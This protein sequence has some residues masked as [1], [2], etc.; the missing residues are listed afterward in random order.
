L[1]LVLDIWFFCAERNKCFFCPPCCRVR[2]PTDAK[3]SFP[4]PLRALTIKPPQ[5][6]SLP[7]C[8]ACPQH[9][10][11]LSLAISGLLV[12]LPKAP[13]L[14]VAAQPASP[15]V[16]CPILPCPSPARASF[17]GLKHAVKL[18]H[19]HHGWPHAGLRGRCATPLQQRRSRGGRARLPR[20]PRHACSSLS[21]SSRQRW[22]RASCA[23]SATKCPRWWWRRWTSSPRQSG[24]LC[25]V[26]GGQAADVISCVVHCPV[27]Q[28]V[29]R[30]HVRRAEE[31]LEEHKGAAGYWWQ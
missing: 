15:C 22:W 29:D 13:S 20:Q 11:D 9:P 2:L 17:T 26:V 4:L 31:S 25:T 14:L 3:H 5:L 24:A 16:C 18:P 12:Q 8:T 23:P 1:L 10:V 21:W 6:N 27:W 28:A 30:E 19:E 7:T